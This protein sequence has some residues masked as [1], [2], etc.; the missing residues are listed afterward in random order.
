M[1]DLAI[2]RF[3]LT[4]YV[5]GLG[6]DEV[7]PGEYALTCPVCG[8]EKLI[9]NVAKKSWHCWVCQRY[10]V[11]QSAV[12]PRRKA[13][14]GAG[15]LID[16]VQLF[17]RCSRRIAVEK[18][19]AAGNIMADLGQIIA[20]D[21]KTGVGCF[22]APSKP[23]DPPP[24]W[25]AIRQRAPTGDPDLPYCWERGITMDDVNRLGIF[26][27]IGGKYQNR[28]VFPVWE[29]CEL[30]YW[31]ARAMWSERPGEHYV[32][33]LNPPRIEGAAVSSEVLM[34]LHHAK[35]YPRVWITEGPVDAIHAGP[36][37]VCSFGK[38]LSAAQ[39][40][41]LWRAGV[42][43]IDLMFDADARPEMEAFAPLLASLF[44]TRLVFIP[45]GDPG[46]WKRE[47]LAQLRQSAVDVRLPSKLRSI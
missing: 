31:Q 28:L 15:G 8:K 47:D 17:E 27:C 24:F 30:V 42:R 22:R 33:A 37:A 20:G 16:L 29:N 38:S 14:A 21:F 3:D 10:E 4:G 6:G 46:T 25:A 11:V 12:G 39:L 1:I 43:A 19:L 44:D 7:Q 35:N 23:V 32:K 41:R 40:S 34:G 2:E 13:V 26:W 5:T 36:D 45:W 18:V 9:V